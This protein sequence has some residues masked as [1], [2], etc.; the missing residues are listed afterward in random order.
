MKRY[1]K[2][3]L[4][5]D[6]NSNEEK[7]TCSQYKLE[8]DYSIHWTE[9][10]DVKKDHFKLKLNIDN[11]NKKVNIKINKSIEDK[12]INI[13]FDFKKLQNLNIYEDLHLKNIMK[14]KINENK[15]K[16][17]KYKYIILKIYKEYIYSFIKNNEIKT[18]KIVSHDIMNSIDN[19][20]YLD[21]ID[22]NKHSSED[23][24]LLKYENEIK[25]NENPIERSDEYKKVIKY[26]KDNNIQL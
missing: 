9:Q 24:I 25:D 17:E 20:E 10:L 14:M 13:I 4:R 1:N 21:G 23:K 15:K 7:Y 16:K 6:K 8:D 11:F 12:F 22:L 26:L 19:L 3:V 5:Y 18:T 2:E